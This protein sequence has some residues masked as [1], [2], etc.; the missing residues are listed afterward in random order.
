[1]EVLMQKKPQRAALTGR[2]VPVSG[3]LSDPE[4]PL[5]YE[6][7]CVNPDCGFHQFHGLGMARCIL[8]DAPFQVQ[9]L[10]IV[11]RPATSPDAD[12]STTDRTAPEN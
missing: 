8:C 3:R 1:M 10:H 12:D 9:I 4:G 11:E 7:I 5:L 6:A 2:T